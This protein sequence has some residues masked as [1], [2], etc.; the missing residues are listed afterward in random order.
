MRTVI[1]HYSSEK[2]WRSIIVLGLLVFAISYV[3]FFSMHGGF[4][5]YS[6]ERGG[7]WPVLL[8]VSLPAVAYAGWIELLFLHQAVLD[9]RI[10]I[11]IEHDRLIYLSRFYFAARCADI[12]A[13]SSGTYEMRRRHKAI[14]IRMHNGGEK[15][16]P[17]EAL[18]EN[19]QELISTLKTKLLSN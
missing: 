8:L 18:A 5:S 10:A 6:W 13:I 2:I 7:I 4:L 1:A 12:A 9:R 19:Q 16:I 15:L 3:L 11:W 17:S 14:I